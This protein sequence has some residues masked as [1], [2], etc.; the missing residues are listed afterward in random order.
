MNCVNSKHYVHN[1]CVLKKCPKLLLEAVYDSEEKP[2]PEPTKDVEEVITK[3]EVTLLKMKNQ[4]PREQNK[5]LRKRVLYLQEEVDAYRDGKFTNDE[6]NALF[7]AHVVVACQ[8]T[9]ISA[10]GNFS[11][12][13]TEKFEQL[14]RKMQNIK[15]S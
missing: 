11:K 12:K 6:K 4:E 9:F 1:S 14:S 5:I 13:W 7:Q 2:E 10:I 8:S 3:N 15:V